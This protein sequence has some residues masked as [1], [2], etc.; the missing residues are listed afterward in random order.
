MSHKQLD[1]KKALALRKDALLA[2]N[3]AKNL[4]SG[5]P[6]LWAPHI[7]GSSSGSD[8]VVDLSKDVQIIVSDAAG[9]AEGK[10]SASGGSVI[11]TSSSED[12]AR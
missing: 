10:R 5:D 4:D 12:E 8:G 9:G 7:R 11:S 3:M 1:K 6:K 2:S